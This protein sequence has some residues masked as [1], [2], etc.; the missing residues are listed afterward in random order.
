MLVET[1]CFRRRTAGGFDR[2]GR[3]AIDSFP[4]G[5]NIIDGL[6]AERPACL[7]RL[8]ATAR[9]RFQNI[10]HSVPEHLIEGQRVREKA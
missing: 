2:A 7:E 6:V 4:S 3:T 5:I 1:T 9:A 10:L 8:I